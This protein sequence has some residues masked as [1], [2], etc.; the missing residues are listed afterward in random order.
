MRVGLIALLLV[1]GLLVM[2]ILGGGCMVY[3]AYK[4]CIR[5]DEEVHAK[6]ADI[7]VVLK[8]RY[9][10]IPN[11]VS[12]VKGYAKH[13]SETLEKVIAA[14]NQAQSATTPSAAA[15]AANALSGAMRMAINVVN[16]RYPDLK[17]NQ[18][19]RDLMVELEGSENRI[20]EMRKRYNAVVKQLNTH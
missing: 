2:S 9:D 1:L 8:R 10:L 16:E 18:N 19:F 15:A 12:T 13:E 17:A 6:W 4:D 3:G 11:F 20:A 5:L 14:R 7:D